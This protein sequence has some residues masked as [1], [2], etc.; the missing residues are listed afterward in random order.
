MRTRIAA[1]EKD[2]GFEKAER[3]TSSDQGRR[4]ER[5]WRRESERWLMKERKA[6]VAIGG[7]DWAEPANVPAVMVEE[8]FWGLEIGRIGGGADD[9]FQLDARFWL[10][11]TDGG[12]SERFNGG[13]SE[14]RVRERWRRGSMDGESLPD[15]Q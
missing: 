6:G 8:V 7:W 12:R 4:R 1:S 14:Y 11:P 13:G 15:S 2:S 5:P 10:R 9:I 3:S